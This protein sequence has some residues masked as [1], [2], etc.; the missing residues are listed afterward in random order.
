MPSGFPDCHIQG[1]LSGQRLISFR[2]FYRICCRYTFRPP[3]LTPI[4]V[5]CLN[6]ISEAPDYYNSLPVF[7][8]TL[9]TWRSSDLNLQTE[10]K[11]PIEHEPINQR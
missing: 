5:I 3:L 10:E 1:M 6:N 9:R 4:E 2:M 8:G 7:A 11:K